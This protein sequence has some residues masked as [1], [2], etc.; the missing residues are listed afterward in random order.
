MSTPDLRKDF[1]T[2]D[3]NM[4]ISSDLGN[5]VHGPHHDVLR[6]IESGTDQVRI[7]PDGTVVGGTTNIG[8]AKMDW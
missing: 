3:P 5:R 6:A 8:K 2:I 4:K 7:A 1:P